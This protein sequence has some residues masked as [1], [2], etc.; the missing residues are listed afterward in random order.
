MNKANDNVNN[1]KGN[2]KSIVKW[3]VGGI[4]LA[5]GIWAYHEYRKLSK[6]VN[7]N[8]D[9]VPQDNKAIDNDKKL[10]ESDENVDYFTKHGFMTEVI[11]EL[12][13]D[14]LFSSDDFYVLNC[15]DSDR[16][17]I[18]DYQYN[19][20]DEFLSVNY[21]ESTGTKGGYVD[22]NFKINDTLKYDKYHATDELIKRIKGY[23]Q[24]VKDLDEDF[25]PIKFSV[26]SICFHPN[27]DEDENIEDVTISQLRD[28]REVKGVRYIN[29]RLFNCESEDGIDYLFRLLKIF[30]PDGGEYEDDLSLTPFI[31]V[32][33]NGKMAMPRMNNLAEAYLGFINK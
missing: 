11:R 3:I 14:P 7:I 21:V 27:L 19:L 12:R 8:E 4:T 16:N 30:H 1:P 5:V 26:K 6:V 15:D 22:L 10:H 17:E 25:R 23:A 2:N 9:D 31:I 13:S 20:R 32:Y 29:L 28:L 18:N 24:S 33:D